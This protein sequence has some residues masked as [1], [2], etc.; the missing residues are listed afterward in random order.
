MA[1]PIGSTAEVH[2][3]RRDYRF[4]PE[5]MQQISDGM[6][7]FGGSLK[8]TAFVERAI[9]H[10]AEFLAGDP[11]ALAPLTQEIE[12]LQEH[13]RRLRQDQQGVQHVAQSAAEKVTDQAL[14]VK[15]LQAQLRTLKQE[16][17]EAQERI[18]NLESLWS[19]ERTSV[20]LL[21]SALRQ[22]KAA[23]PEA[24]EKK[25][26]LSKAYEI[27][28]RHEPRQACP[29]LPSGFTYAEN[30][31]TTCIREKNWRAHDYA[32][33]TVFAQQWPIARVRREVERLKTV[34]GL[35]SIWIAKNGEP[36]H[37]GAGYPTDTWQKKE[38]RWVKE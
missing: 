28:I 1:R 15:Q 36:V 25:L 29:D 16:H 31:I 9:V 6:A 33:H 11:E 20:R 4:A 18:R 17:S 27:K 5:T 7:I 12:W 10:Y 35:L 37:T 21:E 2:K 32:I 14:E 23:T 26:D 22:A 34:P 19:Q 8:E 3:V 30:E 38:G 24:P 13:V